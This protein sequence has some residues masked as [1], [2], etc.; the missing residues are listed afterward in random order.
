M[1]IGET[2][3]VRVNEFQYYPAIITNVRG[4]VHSLF[5]LGPEQYAGHRDCVLS[6]A[7][8][9]QFSELDEKQEN[10]VTLTPEAEINTTQETTEPQDGEKE[11]DQ[12]KDW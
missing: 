8:I 12:E 11:K 5:V 2:V 7:A 10:K 3:K 4:E 6:G 9:G 1:K